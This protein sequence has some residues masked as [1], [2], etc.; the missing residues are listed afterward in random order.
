MKCGDTRGPP[1]GFGEQGNMGNLNYWETKTKYLREQG[2]M[3]HV[4]DQKL[5]TSWM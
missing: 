3:N 2:K 4:R 1:K 5:R